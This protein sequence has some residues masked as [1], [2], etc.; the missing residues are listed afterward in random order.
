LTRCIPAPRPAGAFAALMRPNSFPTNLSTALPPLRTVFPIQG[1]QCIDSVHPCTSP[2]GRIRCAHASKFVP[3]EFVNRSATSP[4]DGAFCAQRD[5]DSTA[6]GDY[7]SY[8]P[9]FSPK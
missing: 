9:C 4:G 7:D 3:D 6:T 5:A 8:T 1:D 2:C